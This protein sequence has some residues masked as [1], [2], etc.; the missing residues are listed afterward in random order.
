[1]AFQTKF[2]RPDEKCKEVGYSAYYALPG[3]LT[4]P[5]I[6]PVASGYRF[7]NTK[8]VQTNIFVLD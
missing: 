1:M 2:G 8:Y 7:L 3:L 4:T 5:I 6:E